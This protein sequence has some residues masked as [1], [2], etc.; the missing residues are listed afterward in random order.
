VHEGFGGSSEAI[1]VGGAFSEPQTLQFFYDLGI[2]VVNTYGLTEGG[3]GAPS[4]T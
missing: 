2:P 3:T 1:I 4:T